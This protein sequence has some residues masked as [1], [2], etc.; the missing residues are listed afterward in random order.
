MSM[1]ANEAEW[2]QACKDV[3]DAM[4]TYSKPF[5]I[6][7]TKLAL[8][9]RPVENELLF[10]KGYAGEGSKFLYNTLL[11]NATSYTAKEVPVPPE[12][13]N[14][15]FHF[16]ID[17]RPDLA[18]SLNP[19]YGLP[20]PRGFSGSLVWNTHYVDSVTQGFPWKP[21]YAEVTGIVWGW[22]SSAA[23]I[24]ATRIE[25]VRSFLLLVID[26]MLC[27]GEIAVT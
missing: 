21:E 7:Q 5:V 18:L 19:G 26:D 20:Q 6:P 2:D 9:H 14:E 1:P 24:L 27:K 23:C 17:Y 8:A 4:R 13:G 16:A 25:Y 15:R 10:F 12:W 11:S 3:A 22:P